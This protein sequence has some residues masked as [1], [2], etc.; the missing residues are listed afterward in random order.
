MASFFTIEGFF[1][2][3]LFLFFFI[4]HCWYMRELNQPFKPH[5]DGKGIFI[6]AIFQYLFINSDKI[7][8]VFFRLVFLFADTIDVA[9]CFYPV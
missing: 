2:I 4:C 7:F 6:P 8:S 3:Y 9:E 5:E 1:R